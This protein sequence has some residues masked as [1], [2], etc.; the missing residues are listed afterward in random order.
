MKRAHVLIG[1]VVLVAVVIAV[2]W[3]N[4]PASWSEAEVATLRSLWIGSLPPLPEDP[5]NAYA[6]DPQAAAFGHAL[7]F[8]RRFSSNNE[9]A[10]ATCHIPDKMFNDGLTLAQVVGTDTRRTMTIV[11]SA[12]SHWLCWDG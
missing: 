5:S 3:M 9:V 4:K 1:G 8:D 11:G 7:F 12:Y 10:C 6:N 2:W